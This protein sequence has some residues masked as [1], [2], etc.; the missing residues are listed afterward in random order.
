MTT[1]RRITTIETTVTDHGRRIT[2]H[3]GKLET[4][5]AWKA[6]IEESTRVNK[7]NTEALL[8]MAEVGENILVA[9]HWVAL[10]AKWVTTIAAAFGVF[11]V[12]FRWLGKKFG[13]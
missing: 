1:E 10:A 9:L 4:V 6:T 2:D 7:K 5:M 8:Q 3:D 12:V 13:I 11:F